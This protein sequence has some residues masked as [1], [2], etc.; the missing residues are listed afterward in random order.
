MDSQPCF[1][2]L[3]GLWHFVIAPQ[4][5]ET[6]PLRDQ[7]QNSKDGTEEKFQYSS[8]GAKYRHRKF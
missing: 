3:L 2:K 6:R 4:P 8:G 7:A 5:T 1:D